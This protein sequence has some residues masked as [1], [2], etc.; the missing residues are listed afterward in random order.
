MTVG[1]KRKQTFLLASE[2]PTS[3]TIPVFNYGDVDAND[4]L[5]YDANTIRGRDLSIH[6]TTVTYGILN[7][8]PTSKAKP[9]K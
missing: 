5:K 4:T 3:I 7:I 2:M 8:R 9:S 1:A 6:T